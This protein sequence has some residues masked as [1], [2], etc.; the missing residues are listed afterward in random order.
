[1]GYRDG[2][3][4]IIVS[5]DTTAKVFGQGMGWTAWA[6]LGEAEHGVAS[7]GH[8]GTCD[9]Q[10]LHLNPFRA[11][12]GERRIHVHSIKYSCICYSLGLVFFSPLLSSRQQFC[13]CLLV[14]SLF[15]TMPLSRKGGGGKNCPPP[16]DWMTQ[17]KYQSAGWLR[18]WIW[19]P[20]ST[21]PRLGSRTM[22]GRKLPFVARQA[23][24]NHC[25]KHFAKTPRH[26]L[27]PLTRPRPAGTGCNT[28]LKLLM[29]TEGGQGDG[30][31]SASEVK[32]RHPYTSKC[33]HGQDLPTGCQAGGGPWVMAWCCCARGEWGRKYLKRIMESSFT[34]PSRSRGAWWRAG[35][36]SGT[37]KAS[38]S[39]PWLPFLLGAQC[40]LQRC[41]CWRPR[42]RDTCPGPSTGMWERG[43][44]RISSSLSPPALPA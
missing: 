31:P 19:M 1:M 25:S 12:L 7:A 6:S 32:L 3:Q 18:L 17:N 34:D 39:L 22:P 10:G 33:P 28:T 30:L 29:G 16:T 35:A 27:T 41:H 36:Q 20:K 40:M 42:S 8:R 2:I 9:E 4:E 23:V 15:V 11:L 37:G 43:S 44:P 21:W 13:D 38:P 24:R 5:C 14:S 26:R